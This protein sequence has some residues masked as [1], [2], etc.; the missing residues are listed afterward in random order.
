MF[1]N[2][3]LLC[4]R[5]FFSKPF[6]IGKFFRFLHYLD[7]FASSY[8]NFLS[9]PSNYHPNNSSRQEKVCCLCTMVYFLAL[10]LKE[11]VDIIFGNFKNENNEK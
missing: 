1:L 9:G 2:E 8:S 11:F 3:I 7:Y 4:I 6:E 5:K 10:G